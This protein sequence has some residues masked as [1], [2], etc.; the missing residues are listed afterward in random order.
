MFLSEITGQFCKTVHLIRNG[1]S[2]IKDTKEDFYCS[3]SSWRISAYPIIIKSIETKKII[4]TEPV[5]ITYLCS[6]GLIQLV[7]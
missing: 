3:Q 7:L 2:N 4:G 1:I 5:N 6:L